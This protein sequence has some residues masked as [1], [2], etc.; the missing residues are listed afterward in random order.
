[1]RMGP[2]L[3]NTSDIA[4]WD[5]LVDRL[6]VLDVGYLSGG[7]AWDGRSS[8][9]T[10]P[11]DV[12]IPDLI[13]D[14]AHAPHPRLRDAL[15]ALLFRHPEYA[16]T[17]REVA[18]RMPR[19]DRARLIL[20]ASILAAAALRRAWKFTLDIYLPGQL[21]IDADDIAAELGVPFPATDYGR[22]C[23]RALSALLARDQPFPFDYVRAWE[24]VAEHILDG[25]R[26]QAE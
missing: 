9:Y 8:R 1:M 11:Q 18:T 6:R 4:L 25:L 17:A 16:P 24:D 23:L 5:D 19:E 7:S 20:L 10:R 12:Q 22:A 3:P 26:L 21:A 2:Y 13:A 14:L 15:V